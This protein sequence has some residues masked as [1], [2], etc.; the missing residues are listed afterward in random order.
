VEKSVQ[1]KLN[2]TLSTLRQ[3]L[4]YGVIGVISNATG[5]LLYLI[6]THFGAPPILA[7]TLLYAVGATIG[8]FGHRR[9]TFSYTGS[10]FGS[11]LR[12]TIVHL[13]GYFINLAILV[14]FV[15]RLGYPHQLVQAVAIF[16]VAAFLFIMFK[17]FVFRISPE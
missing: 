1:F 6:V 4:K 16:I 8:F 15:D 3:L 11:G 2:S 13:T 5:Y 14:E 17:L 10:V 7:M 12:Y 9:L